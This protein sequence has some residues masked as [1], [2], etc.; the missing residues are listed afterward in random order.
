MIG[1]WVGCHLDL[2]EC[3]DGLEERLMGRQ[4]LHLIVFADANEQAT[5]QLFGRQVRR[6]GGVVHEEGRMPH[7]ADREAVW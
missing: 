6:V 4:R 7:G 3:R 2:R 5:P 1:P